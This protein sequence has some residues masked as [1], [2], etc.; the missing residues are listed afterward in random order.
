MAK[1][2]TPGG[3]D[4]N[5][6]AGKKHRQAEAARRRESTR[7]AQD[8]APIPGP[9][10]EDPKRRAK[11]EKSLRL[12][13]ETYFPEACR[14][15]WSKDHLT[16]I[17]STERAI[18]ERLLFALAMPRG[19]GKS[20]LF[21]I[22]ALWAIL[23]GRCRFVCL[24]AA[25]ADKGKDE[26]SKMKDMLRFNVKLW[27]DFKRELHAIRQ[28][29]GEPRRCRGQTF[30]GEPT[31]IAWGEKKIVFPTIPG[32][33]AS[34]AILTGCGLSGGDIR[35][36]SHV[37]TDGDTVL[38]P[39]L[40]LVDD[41]QTKESARSVTQTRQRSDLINH[42][43]LGMFGPGV[44]PAG[45]AAMTVIEPDDLADRMLDTEQSPRWGGQRCKM[46]YAMPENEALWERYAEIRRQCQRAKSSFD[47]LNKFYADNREE[48]ERGA[49][50][51]W[52]ERKADDEW[53]GLQHAMNLAIDDW[54][55]FQAEY[56]NEPERDDDGVERLSADDVTDKV[57]GLGR[58]IVARAREK[59]TAAIDVHD[60]VLY[61]EVM[62]WS[63]G[64]VGDVIDYGTWPKQPSRHF[65][66]RK[67]RVKM[68]DVAPDGADVNG[69][70]LHGLMELTG[71]L[72]EKQ[73]VRE[74][75]TAMPIDLIGID[76]GYKP[77]LVTECIARSPHAARM[78]PIRGDG[79]TAA[80]KPM[81]E[82]RDVEGA[83]VG[84]HWRMDPVKKRGQLR[85]IHADVNYWK[86]FTHRCLATPL[87]TPGCVSFWGSKPDLHRMWAEHIAESEYFIRTEGR[88][89]T[90]DQWDRF[91]HQPDNHG[92][93]THVYNHVLASFL[94]IVEATTS[95]MRRKP[96]KRRRGRRVSYL[97]KQ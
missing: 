87:G 23:T 93:D 37:S 44:R 33:K 7:A 78:R 4:R 89:R 16:A 31:Q 55:A 75:G 10:V 70:I 72:L 6:D 54:R 53:S 39:D 27:A 2:Q 25:T 11:A 91:T 56:Q 41:P 22:A 34:G 73:Y 81:D 28:L 77:K 71:E 18:D 12:F 96:K 52:P 90:V 84:D 30:E 47:R 13:A 3:D 38:R 35:G 86:T 5:R 46:L 42:D 97:G 21:R 62:A 24:I 95:K 88:G 1:A 61:Y 29:E 40:I 60:G 14:W 43:V 92:F 20:T 80:M 9:E 57:N 66:M 19:S 49:E 8:V 69:A 74:D 67:A 26:L 48:L 79:I 58:Y 76:R 59:I 50:V 82:Y 32:S 15:A 64:F 83:L 17:K 68:I 45:F 51:A 65:I 63:Q 85:H 36:Q 94:G